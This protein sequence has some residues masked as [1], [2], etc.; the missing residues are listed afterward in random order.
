MAKP[1]LQIDPDDMRK[2]FR[3]LKAVQRDE[4]ITKGLYESG[5][6]F[7]RWSRLNRMSGRP[8]LRAP[9]GNLRGSV[10]PNQARK[11]GNKFIV[12]IGTNVRYVAKHECGIGVPKRAFLQP[13]I[14]EADNQRQMVKIMTRH[15]NEALAK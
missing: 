4:V 12:S 13:S 14:D 3:K 10:F 7:A 11:I 9:T 8:G 2:L 15:I 5:L 1:F 6:M